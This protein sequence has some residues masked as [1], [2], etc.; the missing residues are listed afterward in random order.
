MAVQP[1]DEVIVVICINQDDPGKDVFLVFSSPE[2]AEAFCNKDDRVHVV[3]N[4]IVDFPEH[5]EG[6]MN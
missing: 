5:H 2:A 6:V 3:S 1:G 4:R